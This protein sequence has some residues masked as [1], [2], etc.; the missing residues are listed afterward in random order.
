MAMNSRISALLVFALVAGST[1]SAQ[2]FGPQLA[3]GTPPPTANVEKLPVA[4]VAPDGSWQF[5]SE[6]LDQLLGPIAL[7]PDALI[8]L[9]LP[10]ATTSSDVVLAARYL[11]GGSAGPAAIDDQTWDDSV[12]ALA[13]YPS[14]VAWMDQNLAWTKQVGEAFAT[15]PAEVMKSIQR[16]RNAAR[17]AGTLVDTPQQQVVT[18]A[19]TITII[20]AQPDVIYV[21]Y[22]DPEIV[23]VRR[24]NYPYYSGSF[25]SFSV[26]YPVGFWLGYNVDWSHRRIWVVDR[27]ERERYW[28]ETRDW[29]RPSFPT[30]TVVIHDSPR[31]PWTPSPAYVKPTQPIVRR[32]G[33]PVSRPS[34][35]IALETTTRSPPS[36][37]SAPEQRD[38]SDRARNDRSS[39][40]SQPATDALRNRRSG[41]PSSPAGITNSSPTG[42]VP[43]SSTTTTTLPAPAPAAASIAPPPQ[44]YSRGYRAPVPSSSPAP[45]AQRPPD[46]GREIRSR[47]PLPTGGVAAPSPASSAAV[48]S[49]PAT[50]P[51]PVAAAPEPAPATSR[52]APASA[53]ASDSG[54]SPAPKTSYSRGR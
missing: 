37:W 17:A 22:Y 51:A 18:Q 46:R 1:M 32:A 47:A 19:E 10:A 43:S 25:F 45:S 11:A 14:V 21:P 24:P 31:R 7:Y 36:S 26:G 49:S 2:T 13:H 20:P 44:T 23:Y 53:P 33:I 28:R 27:R 4:G 6:Q 5:T 34:S 16:L 41:G 40:L 38:R 48:A 30:E 15:Q 52:S 39:S 3:P 54:S 42:V 12:K 50:S 35:P 29:R 9:I 8:A